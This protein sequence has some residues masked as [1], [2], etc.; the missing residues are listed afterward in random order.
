M[1][2]VPEITTDAS[3]DKAATITL[4]LT[5]HPLLFG[6]Y[7]VISLHT[8]TTLESETIPS[9]LWYQEVGLQC[10]SDSRLSLNVHM[11]H[12]LPACSTPFPAHLAFPSSPSTQ[13]PFDP[14]PPGGIS[15]L[16]C[17]DTYQIRYWDIMFSVEDP[18][19]GTE[20]DLWEDFHSSC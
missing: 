20:R 7:I 13:C 2:F 19:N 1:V 11:A 17:D 16:M 9:L 6:F 15:V 8:I 12:E 3:R 5:P 4:G 18:G 10:V 14:C